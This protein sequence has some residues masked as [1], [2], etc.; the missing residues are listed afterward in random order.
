MGASVTIPFETPMVVGRDVGNINL[1]NPASSTLRQDYFVG[2]GAKA[3][4]MKSLKMPGAAVKGPG[5]LHAGVGYTIGGDVT[6]RNV[7]KSTIV[8]EAIRHLI[9]PF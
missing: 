6:V 4:T 8:T 3:T 7:I 2:V 1:T 9:F 5:E